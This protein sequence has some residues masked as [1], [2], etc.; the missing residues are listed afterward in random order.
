VF[1]N[2]LQRKDRRFDHQVPKIPEDKIREQRSLSG[3]PEAIA[4]QS[5]NGQNREQGHGWIEDPVGDRKIV[6]QVQ[7]GRMGIDQKSD[8]I[9][10]H[11]KLGEDPLGQGKVPS[12]VAFG[13]DIEIT[14]PPKKKDQEANEKDHSYGIKQRSLPLRTQVKIL[15]KIEFIESNEDGED[16]H[17][18]LGEEAQE[19]T[20]GR[21]GPEEEPFLSRRE[22]SL[23]IEDHG[24]KV[25]H[26][27]HGG[28]SLDDV[29]YRLGL[30]GMDKEDETREEGDGK[31]SG[32]IALFEG[33]EAEGQ[34]E[35]PVEQEAGTEM[36]EEIDQVKAEDLETSE[37][38]VQGK[39][40][41]GENPDR[42]AVLSDEL[43]DPFQ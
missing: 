5:N 3:R 36:D 24:Q 43:I 7:T 19:V 12:L 22:S 39:G 4:D 6:I 18:L 23:E 9:E 37:V 15:E 2:H 28:H 32:A 31:G 21:P 20:Q 38:I 16:R 10:D 30:N 41:V 34:K 17:V 8:I 1:I 13:D 27:G 35:K 25:E 40:D 42:I 29:G 26:A 11:P 14:H 33:G